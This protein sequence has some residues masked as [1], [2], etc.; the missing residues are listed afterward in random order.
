MRA[1]IGL[2]AAVGVAAP[3]PYPVVRPGIVLRFPADH[4]AHPAFRT[5]WWYVTGWLHTA[6]GEDL[7]FQVTFFRTRPPVDPRNPSR[8]AAGQVLFAHAALSDPKTG[9]LLH[10]EKAARAGFGLAQAR[11]GDADVAIRD[12]RLRRSEDGRWATRVAADGFA[13]ALDFRPTQPPLPQ[14]QGGYSRKGPKP[15]Q[16]SYYYSVPHLRV[17]GRVK[18]GDVVAAVTGEA[19]LDREWSS[20]Y[21][22]PA[23]QGWDWTG[24]NF[25][26][27][28]AMIAFRIRRKGGGTLWT[29]GSLRR[30]DGRTTVFGPNDV[31][32]RPLATW[33]SK[34]TGA[35][36]P[37]SQELSVRVDSGVRRWRLV[38]MFAAQE[39][40]ARRGGLPVYWEGAVRTQGGRGYLELTGYAQPLAM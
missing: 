29:G 22:A 8:F 25:D 14:G 2:V 33:R 39:L 32:F 20:D 28:S 18:R 15:D 11:K 34:A 31:A 19:W 17:T 26:D 4:G 23:A 12:W 3:A 6:A 24:L 27:G 38:P 35:V 30:A 40:D 5:E 37:V 16:A 13:L 7:G 1:L 21:L 9:K 36:Y 10:G